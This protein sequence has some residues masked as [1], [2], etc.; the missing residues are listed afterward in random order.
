MAAWF[1]DLVSYSCVTPVIN[2]EKAA[3]L[4][5]TFLEKK[6]RTC[7]QL[8]KSYEEQY[9]S[10]EASVRDTD[11]QQKQTSFSLQ[12]AQCSLESAFVVCCEP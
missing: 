1:I 3:L 10:V 5:Q 4:S 11:Q 2:G 9:L 6:Q 12:W 7:D 8:L